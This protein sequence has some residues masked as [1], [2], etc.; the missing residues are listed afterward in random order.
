M[1]ASFFFFEKDFFLS[2]VDDDDDVL[3]TGLIKIAI[4]G[5]RP[6][7]HNCHS[8]FSIHLSL[9]ISSSYFWDLFLLDLFFIVVWDH[10]LVIYVH[11]FSLFLFLK[12]LII[13]S[14]ALIFK[15]LLHCHSHSFALSSFFFFLYFFLLPSDFPSLLLP[16]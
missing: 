2:D 4:S 15:F 11:S 7:R 3:P 6:R 1:I 13:T 12:F 16:Y 14:F 5:A 10:S 9:S 8:L